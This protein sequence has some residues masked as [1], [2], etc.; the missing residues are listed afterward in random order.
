MNHRSLRI[1]RTGSVGLMLV[2]MLALLVGTF[3]VSVARRA[4]NERHHVLHHQSIMALQSAIEA[5][6]QSGPDSDAKV[7]LPL[8][9]DSNRWIMVESI[10]GPETKRQYQATLYHNDQPSLSIQRLARSDS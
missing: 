5:V 1:R 9:Q 8:D 2:L 10:G 4:S 7:R 3:A 6:E